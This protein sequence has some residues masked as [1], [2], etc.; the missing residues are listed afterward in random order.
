MLMSQFR[1]FILIL[2]CLPILLSSCEKPASPKQ[3]SV[4]QP[5]TFALRINCG[6]GDR[7]DPATG[8]VWKSDMGYAKKGKKYRFEEKPIVASFEGPAPRDV[9]QTVRRSKVLYQF[10]EVPDGIYKVRLHFMD[11]T[12][13]H[14]RSMDFWVDGAPVIQ[15]LNIKEFSYGKARAMVFE[16]IVEVKGGDGME[17]KGSRG[18]GDDVFVSAI[19]V[20]AAPPGA[21]P[22]KILDAAEEKPSDLAGELRKFAGGPVRLVWSRT[23]MEEDFY[24]KGNSLLYGVDSED[25]GSERL[26]L[27]ESR[28]YS[29]PLLTPDGQK[30]IFTDQR[31]SRCYEVGF[32]GKNLRELVPGFASDVWMDPQTGRTWLYVRTGWRDVN[33]PVVRY[34]LN[35]LSVQETVWKQSA[36]GCTQVPWFSLSGDGKFAADGFPWPQCGLADLQDGDFK[37]M[38]KGCWPGVAPDDSHKYFYFVGKHTDIDF[39][40]AGAAK[41]RTIRLSTIPGW[42]GRKVY[43][44]RW[45]NHVRYITTTAPQWMP[46]TE[47]YLGR[48]DESYG[49][50]EDWFRVT[51]NET[52][53]YYGDAWFA[54]AA[55]RRV[56]PG[57]TAPA[58]TP[59][60][61]AAVPTVSQSIPGLVFVWE[62]ERAKNATVDDHGKVRRVWSVRYDGQT[63]PNRWYGA[64]IRN[65]GILPPEDTAETVAGTLARS[66]AIALS[67]DVTDSYMDAA[68]DGVIAFLG[69]DQDHAVLT[70]EQKGSAVSA[71]MHA[72]SGESITASFGEAVAGKPLQLVVTY[73]GGILKTWT[74]GR[75]AASV[76]VQADPATWNP[77]S[78]TFGR[79]PQGKRLW[80]GSLENLRVYD[81]AL[82]AE[83]IT[84]LYQASDSEWKAREPLPQTIVE[85][86]LIQASEPADPETIAPYT[87]SLAE[88]LY[89]VKKVVS[90]EM[91][92]ESIVVLQWVI[93][94]GK[95]LESAD[96]KEGQVYRLV[97]EPADEH[98]QLSGEHRSTDLLDVTSSIY[99]DMGS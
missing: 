75:E 12:K 20:L 45:T 61:P 22:T 32:D 53:D 73:G 13:H 86:E 16:E 34:D 39:F 92:E 74:N 97:L 57:A 47:L 11:G 89:K 60:P 98:S 63:R 23:D 18:R 1:H 84:R 91:K 78:L 14:N 80:K 5:A 77:V 72:A 3:E 21:T 4:R 52:A 31:Q 28:S 88:N 42:S 90:G 79:T 35:D 55:P 87:R 93:L 85:A 64:D 62:N 33:A 81:R 82:T 8:I 49:K 83:E 37:F 17:I 76:N 68:A 71:T 2:H 58:P 24:I 9:Y 54:S 69:D 67:V 43:H 99:Y 96:R 70:L 40:D 19:E 6:G 29:M 7:T 41:P 27:P 15:N 44:P 56:A 65:G 25:G 46:E 38:G 10:K 50:I 26:I 30:I 66:H 94:G 36:S 59:G 51:Y 95:P 48:F